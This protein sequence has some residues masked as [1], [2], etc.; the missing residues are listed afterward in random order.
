[1]I[2]RRFCLLFYPF[3]A[4]IGLYKH[5]FSIMSKRSRLTTE[6]VFLCIKFQI[7]LVYLGLKPYIYLTIK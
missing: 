3:A 1:M 5:G 6:A 7:F 4:L 2:Y